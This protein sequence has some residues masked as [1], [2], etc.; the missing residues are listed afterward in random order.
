MRAG[1]RRLTLGLLSLA[2]LTTVRSAGAQDLDPR[3]YAPSPIGVRFVLAGAGRSS[4]GVVVDPAL[5]VEDVHA[6]VGIVTAAAGTT[7]SLFGRSAILIAAVPIARAHATGRVGETIGSAS[8]TGLADP[9]F[10]LGVNLLGGRAMRP[11]EFAKARTNDVIGVS[12]VVAPPLGQYLPEKL[13]NL[14]ANRWSFKPEVGLSHSV[15]RWT[16]EG[17][18]GVWLF[19][20]NDSF[21][22]GTSTRTQDPVVALQ[23]HATYTLRPRMWL[24]FDGTWYSGGSTSVDGVPKADLQ[25]NSRLGMT[26][27][28]PVLSNQ[29][30]K[31]AYNTGATTRIGGDFDTVSVSWQMSWMAREPASRP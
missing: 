18:T 13:V 12:L 27:A 4:G 25:R 9:R 5:P 29:T 1:S 3:S 21:Y 19:T 10:K 2:A 24:A 31:V 20:A 30:L 22:P 16:L 11:A 14:G 8:R 15:R 7:F 26:F 6:T 17:Y 23:G 28:L